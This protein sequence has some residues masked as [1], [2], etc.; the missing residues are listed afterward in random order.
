MNTT[1]FARYIALPAVSA[2]ID[3]PR[4]GRP[5]HASAFSS[6]THIATTAPGRVL[7]GMP[8][9]G[10]KNRFAGIDLFI[11]SR[12]PVSNWKIFRGESLR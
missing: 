7:S 5:G 2:A 12:R 4:L 1:R 3:T 11:P 6:R 9:S 10:L 8:G